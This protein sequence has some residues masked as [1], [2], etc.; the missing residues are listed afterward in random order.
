MIEFAQPTSQ[1]QST[2]TCVQPF[3]VTLT[4]AL[5]QK[6]TWKFQPGIWNASVWIGFVSVIWAHSRSVVQFDRFWGYMR[7][8]LVCQ[9][10]EGEDPLIVKILGKPVMTG[11]ARPWPPSESGTIG[12]V[13]AENRSECFIE[14]LGLSPFGNA[15]LSQMFSRWLSLCEI[16][17]SLI[18]HTFLDNIF[19]ESFCNI[20]K[21]IQ[22]FISTG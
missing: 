11:I 6:S 17:S 4:G 1:I 3:L 5:K 9:K 16:C 22:S 8:I 18:Y 2:S 13:S 14:G 10:G 21:Y 7:N 15:H 20:M 12:Y 19:L